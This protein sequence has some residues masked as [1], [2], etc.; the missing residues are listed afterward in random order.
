[1]TEYSQR[2]YS[3]SIED[4]HECAEAMKLGIYDRSSAEKCRFD[5][6]MNNLHM[7]DL[8]KVFPLFRDWCSDDE[9]CFIV[10]QLTRCYIFGRVL[11][12]YIL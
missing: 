5:L 11:R 2:M 1:M 7:R 12:K 10:V 6:W 8:G 4:V 9:P 3:R